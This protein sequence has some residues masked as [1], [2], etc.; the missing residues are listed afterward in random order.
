MVNAGKVASVSWDKKRFQIH[1]AEADMSHMAVP[2]R[3]GVYDSKRACLFVF[4][5]DN[6]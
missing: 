4:K 1:L 2:R 5:Q 3:K 6:V